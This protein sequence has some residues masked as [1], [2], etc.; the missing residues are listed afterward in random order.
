MLR[1]ME[2]DTM[3]RF[4]GGKR[5]LNGAVTAL[6]AAL[7]ISALACGAGSDVL[8]AHDGEL[9]P[10]S[11]A[12]APSGDE[13]TMPAS[14]ETDGQTE[15]AADAPIGDGQLQSAEI[16]PSSVISCHIGR[17]SCENRALL[18]EQV[19]GEDCLCFENT[20]ACRGANH[21]ELNCV[22]PCCAPTP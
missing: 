14:T 19:F 9:S 22:L 6:G 15:T 13:T 10:Q 17:A 5:I 16:D 20:S 8:D 7:M 3:S 21:Y 11:E 12:D 1:I 18:R 4:V 2:L